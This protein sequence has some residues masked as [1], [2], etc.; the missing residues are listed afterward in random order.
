MTKKPKEVQEPQATPRVVRVD[1]SDS[2]QVKIEL[3]I[4]G[5]AENQWW[6]AALADDAVIVG[7]PNHSVLTQEEV[8][9]LASDLNARDEQLAAARHSLAEMQE[10]A[11]QDGNKIAVLEADLTRVKEANSLLYAACE[12][13]K[14]KLAAMR[15]GGP[16]KIDDLH[17]LNDLPAH[18]VVEQEIP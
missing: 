16:L 9:K 3:A 15:P 1:F 13:A 5:Q 8:D 14:S 6:G 10:A 4:D 7:R 2:G 17:S 11:V 12:D 18:P